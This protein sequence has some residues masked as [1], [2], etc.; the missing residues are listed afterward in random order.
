M[1]KRAQPLRDQR[2]AA[3]LVGEILRMHQRQIEEGAQAHRQHQ[4]IA[5]RQ[6][7]IGDAA[8]KAS[9]AKASALPRNMLR[10]N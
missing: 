4:I 1:T 10:G 3:V 7:T 9:V 8:R 2:D 6:R 5:A